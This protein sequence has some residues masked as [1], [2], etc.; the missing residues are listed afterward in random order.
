MIEFSFFEKTCYENAIKTTLENIALQLLE[1][2][3][4]I[5]GVSN[6]TLSEAVLL[7]NLKRFK[8]N[9]STERLN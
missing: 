2:T 9:S 8:S 6:L 7:E 4:G 5:F 1:P 3:F